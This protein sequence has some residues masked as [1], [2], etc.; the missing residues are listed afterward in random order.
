MLAKIRKG[1]KLYTDVICSICATLCTVILV[2]NVVNVIIRYLTD[3]SFVYTEDVTVISMLWIMGLGISVGWMN[4]EHLLINVIDNFLNEK[5][6]AILLF[7]QD[8]LGVGAG[9]MMVILG[10]MAQKLNTG[11]V[12]SV[13]GFDE[14][15]RYIPVLVGGVLL[16]LSALVCVIEQ[17]LVWSG[18]EEK[19]A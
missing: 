14:S 18:K 17:I 16:T 7:I 10:R 11:F 19:K 12:Q 15:F 13:I 9:V 3:A 1:K 4:R 8:I 5:G 2:M 6:M